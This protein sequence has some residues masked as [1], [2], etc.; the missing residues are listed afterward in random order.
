MTLRY[1]PNIWEKSA[2]KILG[3][4]QNR[5]KQNWLKNV[6]FRLSLPPPFFDNVQKKDAFVFGC[7]P[8][9]RTSGDDMTLSHDH[10]T[11]SQKMTLWHQYNKYTMAIDKKYIMYDYE[12][13][14]QAD[15]SCQAGDQVQPALQEVNKST[16][17]LQVEVWT[18]TVL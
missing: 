18:L 1:I 3:H 12:Y 2:S 16:A 15:N 11:T 6:G 5:G 10:D 17:V 9:G 8:L 14:L 7:L 4:C 13:I